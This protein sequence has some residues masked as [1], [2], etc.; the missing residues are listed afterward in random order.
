MRLP[1]PAC[2]R[3]SHRTRPPRD[4][5]YVDAAGVL[6]RFSPTRFTA[7]M[8]LTEDSLE[9]RGELREN[10]RFLPADIGSSMISLHAGVHTL[11]DEAVSGAPAFTA[12]VGLAVL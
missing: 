2:H 10:M 7:Y 1:R 4:S 5:T 11:R 6:A 8:E 12:W 3:P 9:Y